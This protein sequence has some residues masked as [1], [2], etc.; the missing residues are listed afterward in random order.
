L[1][2]SIA[3]YLDEIILQGNAADQKKKGFT[4]KQKIAKLIAGMR[5]SVS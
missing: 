2:V 5:K 4:M 3:L 1:L